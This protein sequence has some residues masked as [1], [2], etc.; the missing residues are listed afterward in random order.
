MERQR[1]IES[2]FYDALQ[3]P[4][5]ERDASLRQACGSDS[6]LLREVRSL[7][8]NHRDGDNSEPWAAA[9]AVQLIAAPATLEPGQSLGPYQIISFIAAGGMGAGISRS[10]STD[11]SR[12]GH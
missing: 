4:A 5:A 6:G 7:V 1:Q 12:G 11:G 9:A 10:R 2:L 3:R 8:A